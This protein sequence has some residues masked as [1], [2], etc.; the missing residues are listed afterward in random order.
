MVAKEPLT[1]FDEYY[2]PIFFG[3]LAHSHDLKTGGMKAFDVN[4]DRIFNCVNN[5]AEFPSH[6]IDLICIADCA[7]FIKDVATQIKPHIEEGAETLLKAQ[8]GQEGIFAGYYAHGYLQKKNQQANP[9]F[10]AIVQ[11][12]NLLA[13]EN[14][15]L[16]EIFHYFTSAVKI[17]GG[18]GQIR[19]WPI[20]IVDKKNL[21]KIK[22]IDPSEEEQWSK[23]NLHYG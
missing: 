18:L 15:N 12:M 20:N 13:Y 21:K 22:E 14:I 5:I 1:L 8:P 11:I 23:W 16:R 6:L 3:L 10:P 19:V 9:L 2:S 7:T 17:G 4:F